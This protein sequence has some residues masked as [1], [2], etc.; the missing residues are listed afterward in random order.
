MSKIAL[1]TLKF[2]SE[3]LENNNKNK[4]HHGD[5]EQERESQRRGLWDNGWLTANGRALAISYDGDWLES[6]IEI[7]G[8]VDRV[9]MKKMIL[10]AVLALVACTD[11]H[12]SRKALEDQG[13]EDI[14]I[15]GYAFFGCGEGDGFRTGFTAKNAK[16]KQ[17]SGVD[18][19]GVVKNCTIRF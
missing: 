16:G 10:L 6:W 14:H 3:A 19:C 13:F 2:L 7:R 11:E 4:P 15:T 12:A 9:V 18:C 1:S 17:V 5:Y 8:C